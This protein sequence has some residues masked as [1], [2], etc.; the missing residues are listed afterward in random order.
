M[1]LGRLLILLFIIGFPL[2]AIIIIVCTWI[3]YFNPSLGW[4]DIFRPM[5][6]AV[7]RRYQEDWEWARKDIRRRCGQEPDEGESDRDDLPPGVWFP[8]RDHRKPRRK[9]R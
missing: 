8:R 9:E 2:L 4:L 1:G 7:M 3:S 6:R 5:R